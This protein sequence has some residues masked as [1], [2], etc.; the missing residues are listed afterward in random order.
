MKRGLYRLSDPILGEAA[1]VH[2][3]AGDAA[4]YLSRYLYEL[5]EFRP[6]FDSLPTMREYKRPGRAPSAR[7]ASASAPVHQIG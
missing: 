3:S 7:R 5:L 2:K 6:E 1:R 4:P